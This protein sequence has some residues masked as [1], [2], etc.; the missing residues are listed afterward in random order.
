MTDFKRGDSFD[1]SGAGITATLNGQAVSDFTGWTGASQVRP[2]RGGDVVATL[3]FQWLDAAQGSFRI[4]APGSTAAWPLAVLAFDVR[5]TAPGGEV[6]TTG[7]AQFNV[8]E[9]ITQ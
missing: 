9:A 5:L 4:S 1:Y 3:D 2:A 8:I 7:A 6:I